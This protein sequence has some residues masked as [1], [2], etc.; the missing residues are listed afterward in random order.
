MDIFK[1]FIVKKEL[2][3]REKLSNIFIGLAA[4]SLGV[5]AVLLTM[6]LTIQ[7]FGLLIAFASLYF[8]W[9]LICK[10]FI[11][12]EYIITNHDLD[13]DK[14][15]NQSERKRL[16]AIDLRTVSEYG[17]ADNLSLDESDTVVK[18]SANHPELDDY[19]LRFDHRE[20]GKSVLL[21]TPSTEMMDII[22][23]ALPRN[24]K[25]K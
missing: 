7:M 10:T 25:N 9:R 11:E 1:E 16:C 3:Q 14:I 17:K 2:S 4:V 12:Y 13:I 23:S 8:G 19:Y 18:A 22:K 20:Y 6:G 5:S 15:T 21:F 24:A